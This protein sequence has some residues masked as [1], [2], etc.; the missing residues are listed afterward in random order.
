MPT[1]LCRYDPLNRLLESARCQ[2]FYNKSRLATEIQG[3]VRRSVFQVG[4]QLL[5][6]GGSGVSNLLATDLQRSVLHTV[7]PDIRQPM[8]YN[9]YGHRPAESGL[10]SVLGFNGERA[11]PVTGHYL[12]GNGY[13]AFNPVLMRFNNPDSLSPFAEGGINAYGY[14]KGDPVNLGDPSGHTPVFLKKILR[15]MRLIKKAPTTPINKFANDIPQPRE[16][17]PNSRGFLGKTINYEKLYPGIDAPK[18]RQ[19]ADYESALRMTELY[20]GKLNL[21]PGSAKYE[22]LRVFHQ[23]RA[24]KS[25]AEYWD[26]PMPGISLSLLNEQLS[27]GFAP[28]VKDSLLETVKK[29]AWLHEAPNLWP[30]NVQIRR[31]P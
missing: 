31:K 20:R 9:V 8:A 29:Y 10:S 30:E 11:D 25:A 24:I 18:A 14:C 27:K 5:A 17:V 3:E 12:L 19:A 2:R 16:G 1:D 26:V 22:D 23:V 15:R 4:D 7:K 28:A 13:R 21:N 6:E